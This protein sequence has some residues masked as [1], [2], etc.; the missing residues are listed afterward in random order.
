[1]HEIKN[2]TPFERYLIELAEAENQKL[3][4]RI[5]ADTE[6][7]RSNEDNLVVYVER[8][9]AYEAGKEARA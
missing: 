3:R 4:D 2:S 5:A 8:R 7:L 9:N 1:M 6:K